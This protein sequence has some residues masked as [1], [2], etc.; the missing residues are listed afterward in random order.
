MLRAWSWRMAAR[1]ARHGWRKLLLPFACTALGVAGYAAV[2]SFNRSVE[3]GIAEHSKLLLGADL[4]LE[5]RRP[6]SGEAESFFRSLGG[7]QSRQVSFASMARFPESRKLR[8]VQVRAL[9]GAYPYYGTLETE[10]ASAA[11]D[12]RR[13][14]ALVDGALLAQLGAEIGDRVLIGRS[15]FRI[16]GKLKRVP[17]EAIA[18]SSIHPRVYVPLAALETESLLQK[19]SL[20]RYRVYFKLPPSVDAER[21]AGEQAPRLAR[22]GLQADTVARRSAVIARNTDDLRRFLALSGL[23]AVLLA[24]IG[25]ASG[26][27]SYI[28]EKSATVALL[29]CLGAR[30]GE[31]FS[32]YLL[33]AAFVGFLGSAVGASLGGALQPW[34]ASAIGDFLPLP[35]RAPIS[36][37][38]LL[39]GGAVGFGCS[40]LFSLW[41]LL[42]LRRMSP[43]LA[44]RVAYESPRPDPLMAP[45][46]LSA[47]LGVVALAAA[48][49]ESWS[50]AAAFTLAISAAV[51]LIGLAATGLVAL[52]RA[53][54]PAGWPYALRQ[55]LA[56]LQRP[57]NQTFAVMLALGSGI[58][59]LATMYLVH[60]MLLEEVALRGAARNPNLVLFDIQRNQREEIARLAAAL[61]VPLLE[62]SPV[63]TMRLAAVNGRHVEEIRRDPRASVPA[64]TL[65][66]EYRSTYRGHLT[67]SERIASGAWHAETP[68]SPAPIPISLEKGIAQALG[69][70]V[71]DEL[72]FEVHGVRL[73]TNVASLREVDWYRLQPNFFVVFPRGALEPASQFYIVTARAGEGVAAS[74]Q[75]AVAEGFPNVSIVDIGTVL[76]TLDL[77]LSRIGAAVRVLALWILAIGTCA[78]A[79][80]LAAAQRQ[81]VIESALLGTLGAPRAQ[82]VRIALCEH[83]LLGMVAGLAGSAVAAG[84]SLG[85]TS[86]FA[87][88]PAAMPLAPLLSLPLLSAALTV[89][90]GLLGSYR[91]TG[92]APLEILR[93][94]A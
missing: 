42:P 88:E 11:R 64:W 94:N 24:A 77:V 41:P 17:G 59:L 38:G 7:E 40:V 58:A 74:F 84:A 72:T 23:A 81:R 26:I 1:D 70:G 3:R 79:A 10:P 75:R 31:A 71:G 16:A 83:A 68:P 93:A 91:A 87:R 15:E 43:L 50:Q 13:G 53:A 69:V 9:D 25:A 55:G 33:Q 21:L 22:L 8:L 66:R 28:K 65:R 34:V 19:G 48:H 49:A 76:A 14:G 57:G 61:G 62:E 44:L 32:V 20:A 2:A 46:F 73:K 45:L 47:V 29:R 85:L 63:V 52:L 90:V 78:L 89:P 35:A 12:F 82:L 27:R 54:I 18:L 39:L 36:I 4:A 5:S 30:S 80:S 37:A 92:R 51:A 67:S 56:N 86:Y 6:F 60:A